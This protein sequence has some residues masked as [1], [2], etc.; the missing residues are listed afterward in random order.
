MAFSKEKMT[1]EIAAGA[2]A[3]QSPQLLVSLKRRFGNMGIPHSKEAP[4]PC[5]G[6]R[7]TSHGRD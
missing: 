4:E 2:E 7:N 6:A 1:K 3:L 5:S